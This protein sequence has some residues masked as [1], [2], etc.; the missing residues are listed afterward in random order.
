MAIVGATGAVGLE[1][2]A[3]LAGRGH[4]ASHV[5]AMASRRSVGQELRFGAEM[6][7]AETR[8]IAR[9]RDVDAVLLAAGARVARELAPE[10]ARSGTRVV[11]TSAA[12]RGDPAVPLVIPEINGAELR[13]VP[14]PRLVAAPNCSTII[15]LVALEPLRRRFGLE[16]VEVTTFQAMSGAGQAATREL[17]VQTRA[18]LDGSTL[19][20]EVFPEPCGFNVFP[21]ESPVDPETGLNVEEREMIDET[22]RIWNEPDA[23]IVPSC[24]RVPALRAHGQSVALRFR[25]RTSVDEIRRVLARDPNVTVQDERERSLFPSLLR[26]IGRDDVLVGRIR[27]SPAGDGSFQLWICGD[28]LRKGAALNALQILDTLTEPP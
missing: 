21:H 25:K 16:H 5:V 7:V 18:R 12:F 22:R 9:L 27:Q 10:L 2:L 14:P 13:R 8:D 3:I 11:D 17:E 26:A 24:F 15:L 1:A 6:L 19:A 23:R 28:H 4:P 20:P